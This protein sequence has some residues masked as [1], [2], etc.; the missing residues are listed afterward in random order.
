MHSKD[1]SSHCCVCVIAQGQFF[2]IPKLALKESF[3]LLLLDLPQKHKNDLSV[4]LKFILAKFTHIH[5]DRQKT[6]ATAEAAALENEFNK[7]NYNETLCEVNKIYCM[8][9]FMVCSHSFS[10]SFSASPFTTTPS[11]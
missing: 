5:R 11:S 1:K 4:T 3:H 8:W 9:K 7:K 2:C 6:A 10:L